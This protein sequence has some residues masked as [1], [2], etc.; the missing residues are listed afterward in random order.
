MLFTFWT[1]TLGEPQAVAVW[2]ERFPKFCVFSDADVL[3]LLASDELREIFSRIAI[4]AC[5]SDIAR[6]VLLKE[7]GGLYVDSHIGPSEGDRLAETLADLARFDLILFSLGWHP[8]FNFMNGV[9]AARRRAP[10]LDLLMAR[11]F[12]NLRS[13]KKLEEAAPGYV[14]YDI[15]VLTGTYVMV[16]CIFDQSTRPPSIKPE[17]SDKVLFHV[18]ESEA[19]SGLV[20]YQ[21]YEYRAPGDHWSERQQR[22]R[23]F[24]DQG[25]GWSVA[26]P[27]TD[28]DRPHAT[29]PR[30]R[31]EGFVDSIS[32]GHLHGWCRAADSTS[33]VEVEV[34]VDER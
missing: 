29:V 13:H 22:E 30:R 21:F 9:V 10:V 7:H 24:K 5:K 27:A 16:D 19:S 18:M 34:L 6:L 12:S 11:A 33:P 15:F 28:A 2:R 20:L 3:A 32:N 17:F 14:P 8:G 23:L 25:S 31:Y 1:G 26:R 4:P